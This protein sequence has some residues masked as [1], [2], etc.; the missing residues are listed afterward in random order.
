MKIRCGTPGFI[1]PEV[2]RNL[3]YDTKVD[4]FSAGVVLY[5]MYKLINKLYFV[6]INRRKIIFKQKHKDLIIIK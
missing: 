4:V 1:A 3:E 5:R 2:L 6:K